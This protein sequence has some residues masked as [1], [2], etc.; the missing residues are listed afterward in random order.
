MVVVPWTPGP[1]IALDTDRRPERDEL[2]ELLDE[3]FGQPTREGPGA[4][5]AVL[6]IGGAGLVAATE[7]AGL[8]NGLL[9]LGCGAI[10]LGL[11]LPMRDLWQRLLRRRAGHRLQSSLAQ[12]LPLN[13]DHPATQA[14]VSAYHQVS[15]NGGSTTAFGLEA[16]EVAHLAMIEVAGLLQGRQPAGS[17]ETEYVETRTRALTGLAK[18]L[19][20]R[21]TDGASEPAGDSEQLHARE[22][23]VAAMRELEALTGGSSVARIDVLRSML[24]RADP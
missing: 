23:G 13:T 21:D 6:L 5:D 24:K 14:L 17:A 19:P 2:D 8:S 12:G 9:A 3:V 16:L 22:A 7:V 20:R 18:V 11:I 4:F 1:L 15:R 10:G